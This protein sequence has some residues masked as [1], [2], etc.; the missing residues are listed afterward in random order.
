TLIPSLH[1]K[2]HTHAR[3]QTHKHTLLHKR[4]H[5]STYICKHTHTH[6]PS[7]QTQKTHLHTQ[8]ASDTPT[9]ML[10]PGCCARVV[11]V[12]WHCHPCKY[13]NP[14]YSRS[15]EHTSELQSHLT[16]VSR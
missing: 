15:E 9:Q 7:Q 16:L 12:V 13:G 10:H 8:K 3:T 11:S 4:A 14:D 6:T 2:Q 5:L 1:C